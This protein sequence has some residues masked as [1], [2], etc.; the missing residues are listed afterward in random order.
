[1]RRKIDYKNEIANGRTRREVTAWVVRV[2]VSV[3]EVNTPIY[4]LKKVA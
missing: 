2:V 4:K 3:G 1:M